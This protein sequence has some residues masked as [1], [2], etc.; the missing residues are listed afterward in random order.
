MKSFME[1]AKTSLAT[2]IDRSDC[3]IVVIPGHHQGLTTI[4]GCT[5]PRAGCRVPTAWCVGC[6]RNWDHRV[7][8]PLR[9]EKKGSLAVQRNAGEDHARVGGF[10][11]NFAQEVM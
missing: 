9:S 5:L 2:L 4:A 8:T 3:K 7:D 1:G 10:V 11:A 6:P